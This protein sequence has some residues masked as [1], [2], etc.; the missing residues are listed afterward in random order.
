MRHRV[1][2]ARL[3]RA[4]VWGDNA[5]GTARSVA[6][7]R[8]R[9]PALPRAPR[10]RI[11]SSRR[12]QPIGG[13]AC[14]FTRRSTRPCAASRRRSSPALAALASSNPADPRSPW[15]APA[16]PATGRV[17][18]AGR[19]LVH[20]T[21][22]E[23][24]ATWR[25][26]SQ[27]SECGLRGILG[28]AGLSV[29]VIVLAVI[30]SG[31]EAVHATLARCRTARRAAARCVIARPRVTSIVARLRCGCT[32]RL[33]RRRRSYVGAA[34]RRRRWPASVRSCRRRPARCSMAPGSVA[35]SSSPVG[36]ARWR[37]A[38]A[39][40]ALAALRPRLAGRRAG[41]GPEGEPPR[42]CRHGARSAELPVLCRSSCS[43]ARNR[44]T[45]GSLP[46]ACA[47]SWSAASRS[48]IGSA[49]RRPGGR[50]RPPCSRGR[51]APASV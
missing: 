31:P 39:V 23:Q 25:E 1:R 47:T 38:A 2:Q 17:T 8:C 3:R 28:S 20:G 44:A 50:P 10:R 16:F 45:G 18:L 46:R 34:G 22:L 26:R 29:D 33:G 35:E 42:R 6:G 30:R 19:V 32:S 36:R 15:C 37:S 5:G 43:K 9:Q 21:P 13:R 40:S 12:K 24:T 48:R 49:D 11:A 7:G 51:R 41:S 14:A 4:V 27:L